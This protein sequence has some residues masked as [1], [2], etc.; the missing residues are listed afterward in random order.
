MCSSTMQWW[1]F[2]LPTSGM[3]KDA[4]NDWA[5]EAAPLLVIKHVHIIIIITV[6]YL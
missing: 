1:G 6:R 3:G 4:L 5:N 2:E